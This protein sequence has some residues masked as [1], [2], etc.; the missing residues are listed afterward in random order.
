M[1]KITKPADQHDDVRISCSR[2]VVVFKTKSAMF[3]KK[4][5]VSTFVNTVE[6]CF[7]PDMVT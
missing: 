1:K 5:N 7:S 2:R 3:R 6:C 4:K